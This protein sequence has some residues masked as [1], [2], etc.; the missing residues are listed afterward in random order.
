MSTSFEIT[1]LSIPAAKMN[2]E[3]SLPPFLGHQ[4]GKRSGDFGT[5]EYAGL[6]IDYGLVPSAFPYREQDN[7]TR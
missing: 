6:F 5:D 7:Y 3:S 2:G 1:K 4:P